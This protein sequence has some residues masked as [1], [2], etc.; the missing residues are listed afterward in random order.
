MNPGIRTPPTQFATM[1]QGLLG[2]P[3][4]VPMINARRVFDADAE[5]YLAAV[6]SADGA[7]LET[8][9]RDAVSD[10]VI[11]CKEDGIWGSILTSSI[12]M[13]ART[14]AG[15][16][17]PLAGRAPTNSNFVRTDY[18]RK[19]GLTADGST[20]RLDTG[21]RNHDSPI[22]STHF[23]VFIASA[24][25]SFQGLFGTDAVARNDST[26]SFTF[27]N[28]VQFVRVRSSGSASTTG[29][30]G[31]SNRFF[32]AS[33]NNPNSFDMR[34]RNGTQTAAVASGVLS[35]NGT[36]WLFLSEGTW[37]AQ[38]IN[39]YS[40]GTAVNLVALESRVTALSAA[41]SAAIP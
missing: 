21:A 30:G 31:V 29:T 40:H 41:I 9:V 24:T 8:A 17:T 32:G 5:R 4:P 38:T 39:F 22:N 11:G 7:P 25:T 15:A 13:G 33:R 20:K 34:I 23:S 19:T 1:P 27:N 28:Q 14:L 12:L 26:F 37:G 3:T 35:L 16:L 2:R 6:E 36:L 10:F 18:N